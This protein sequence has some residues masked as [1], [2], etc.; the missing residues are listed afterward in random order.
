M[1]S[2]KHNQASHEQILE[3]FKGC[4]FDPPLE[5]YT[6]DIDNYIEKIVENAERFECW[7]D[8]ELAGLV[9]M[10]CNDFENK[11]AFI[12]MVSVMT[13]YGG[14]GI[15]KELLEQAIGHCRQLQFKK[16]SLEVSASNDRAIKIYDKFG[17][18]KDGEKDGIVKMKM[19][20]SD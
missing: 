8:D 18:R 5:S 19:K 11:E 16:V 6:P 10:Y 12:T 17:F 2:Y 3:H 7:I 14:R 1:N 15:A 13:K 20:L 9:A 4:A